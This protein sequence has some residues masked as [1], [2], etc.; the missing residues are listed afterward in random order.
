MDVVNAVPFQTY[1]TQNPGDYK[2][3]KYNG[4]QVLYI[5]SAGFD[6]IQVNLVISQFAATVGIG[7]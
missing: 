5:P 3:R 1:Y 4:L 6:T 2:N 7:F